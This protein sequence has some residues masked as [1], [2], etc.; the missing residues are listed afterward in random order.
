MKATKTLLFDYD[1]NK[2]AVELEGQF[3]DPSHVRQIIER[4]TAVRAS[5]TGGISAFLRCDVIP[6]ELSRLAFELCNDVKRKPSNRTKAMG[7][8]S[9]PR[10]VGSDG[11]A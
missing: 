5:D 2:A 8:R 9:L 4:D 3:A 10:S 7:T 11:R 6:A 1:D